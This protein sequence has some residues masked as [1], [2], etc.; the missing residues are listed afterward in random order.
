MFLIRLERAAFEFSWFHSSPLELRPFRHV[1]EMCFQLDD[2]YVDANLNV[3][4]EYHELSATFV[5]HMAGLPILTRRVRSPWRA[6][7]QL[8]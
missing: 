8:D 2:E 6:R 1:R 7:S 5:D 4:H 3:S